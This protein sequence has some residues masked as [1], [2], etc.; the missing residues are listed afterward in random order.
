MTVIF[1]VEDR[2]K[3]LQDGRTSIYFILDDDRP[4]GKIIVYSSGDR[5]YC[6]DFMGPGSRK[7]GFRAVR[8]VVR[9]LKEEY[10][11]CKTFHAVRLTGSAFWNHSPRIT[12]VV[13]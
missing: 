3:F 4:V 12:Q 1:L 6:N 2:R 9:R 8:D 13:L 7:F 10:P 5:L 11:Q